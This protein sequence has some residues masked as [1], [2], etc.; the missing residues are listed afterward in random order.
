MGT[1]HLLRL[2]TG[3][4]L[5][6]VKRHPFAIRLRSVCLTT[7]AFDVLSCHPWPCMLL[8]LRFPADSNPSLSARFLTYFAVEIPRTGSKSLGVG[9][10]GTQ[11]GSQKPLANLGHRSNLGQAVRIL[12][13]LPLAR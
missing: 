1:P 10:R 7:T 9:N 6:S 4:Q 8:N 3:A 2:V 11:V 5:R 12:R 13:T